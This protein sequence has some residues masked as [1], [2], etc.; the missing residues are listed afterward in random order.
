MRVTKLLL[1]VLSLPIGLA[2]CGGPPEGPLEPSATL[3]LNAREDASEAQ[4]LQ[5]GAALT[6]DWIDNLAAQTPT[7]DLTPTATFEPVA[8]VSAAERSGPCVA[9]EGFNL[10]QRQGFCIAAPESWRVL[11]VD[12]GL[13]AGL[14]TTPGQTIS[15]RPPWASE[16][17]VCS[18]LIYIANQTSNFEHLVNRYE[19]IET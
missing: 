5:A 6:A 8:G 16:S 10:E 18:L 4:T 3:P 17:S 14:N 9:P 19:R 13:A 1:I 12:G 15:F 7:A 2:A 11:N